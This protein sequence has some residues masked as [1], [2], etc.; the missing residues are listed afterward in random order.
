MIEGKSF[1]RESCSIGIILDWHAQA[2]GMSVVS[3]F[4]TRFA[5]PQGVPHVR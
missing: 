5:M 4:A 3:R 1:Y 2:N